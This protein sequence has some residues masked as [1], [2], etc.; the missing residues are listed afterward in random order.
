[1]RAILALVLTGCLTTGGSDE[2]V[3]FHGQPTDQPTIDEGDGSGTGTGSGDGS[4]SGTGDGS[5]SGSG[6]GDGSGS[7]SGTGDGS[8][9][10]T[11]DGSG[12]GTGDG[13]GTGGDSGGGIGT[14]DGSGSG[15]STAVE[16]TGT[17]HVTTAIDLTVEALLPEIAADAVELMRTFR[18]SP[19]HALFDLAEDAGVPAVGTIRDA[20]P[21]TLE[22]KV[23]GWLDT[24]LAAYQPIAADI[25]TLA[26]TSLA[27]ATL[28]STLACSGDSATHTLTAVNGIALPPVSTTAGIAATDDQLAIGDHTYGLAYGEIV[29]QQLDIEARLAAVIDCA[30]IAKAVAGK[31]YYGVCVGHE[32]DLRA[33]CE[34][35]V[36]ELVER[37][38]DEIASMRFDVLHF[39]AGTATLRDD[40]LANGVWDAELNA[41]QGLR[42]APAVFTATYYSGSE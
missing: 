28:E 24:Q 41:G 23:Y 8:G 29:W 1:M 21:S 2:S 10:G 31:C 42:H 17:Y 16:V 7:G 25:V 30:A 33:I 13:T 36:D 3:R 39:A 27:T 9:S 32:S 18:D 38:H 14:G 37:A 20:L 34:A 35:G 15:S 11:G 22:N 26:E 4:G 6:T 5:G 40:G 19:G 12:S